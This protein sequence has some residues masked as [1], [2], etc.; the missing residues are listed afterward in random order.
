MYMAGVKPSAT[1]CEMMGDDGGSRP[2]DSV[3]EWAE[4]NG[5]PIIRGEEVIAAWNAFLEETGY[6]L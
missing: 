1:I 4:E 3:K 5:I 6:D 2:F